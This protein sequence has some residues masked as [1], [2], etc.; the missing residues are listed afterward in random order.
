VLTSADEVPANAK[1][2]NLKIMVKAAERHGR[3]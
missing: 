3:Y 1:L 2:E